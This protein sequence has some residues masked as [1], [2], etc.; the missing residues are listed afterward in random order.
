VR[1]DS[2]VYEGFTVPRFYDTLMSKLIV[3]GIDR[4]AAITRMA[5]ALAEYRVAGV[6]TTIPILARIMAHVDFRAGRISTA[7][8]ERALPDLSRTDDRNRSV[9]I[10]AAALW[11]YDR[12]GRATTLSAASPN[13]APTPW[14]LAARPGW[15]RA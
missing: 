8:L 1:D 5:R 7:F 3:W 6:Q 14:R 4:P 13:G 10:V 15:G 9:A 2:G 12:L 11:E